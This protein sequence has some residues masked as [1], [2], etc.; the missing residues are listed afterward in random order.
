MIANKYTEFEED[1][2][3]KGI[4]KMYPTASSLNKTFEMEVQKPK[5]EKSSIIYRSFSFPSKAYVGV[6]SQDNITT[7]NF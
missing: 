3:N 4:S 6:G 1:F 7:Q 2:Y 5:E